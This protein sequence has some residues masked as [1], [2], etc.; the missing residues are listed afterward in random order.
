MHDAMVRRRFLISAACSLAL[1]G[2]CMA[3]AFVVGERASDVAHV[4]FHLKYD[5]ERHAEKSQ[6]KPKE[7][8]DGVAH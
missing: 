5:K 2:G 8:A 1:L 4:L 7:S 6:A 3:W